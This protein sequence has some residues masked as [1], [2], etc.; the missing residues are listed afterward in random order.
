MGWMPIW[1]TVVQRT[2]RARILRQGFKGLAP[3][4]DV[5]GAVEAAV[6]LGWPQLL[7]FVF[8]EVQPTP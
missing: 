8:A 6:E 5:A 2:W 3:A 4:I 1:S 7:K